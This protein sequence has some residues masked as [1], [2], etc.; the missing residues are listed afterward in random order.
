MVK[1]TFF[2]GLRH[3]AI[4]I[5]RDGIFELLAQPGEYQDYKGKLGCKHK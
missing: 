5:V 2:N 4:G 3:P 1:T